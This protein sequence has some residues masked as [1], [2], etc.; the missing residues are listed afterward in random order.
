MGV[1]IGTLR[2]MNMRIENQVYCSKRRFTEAI[3]KPGLFEG[4]KDQLNLN[5]LNK[6]KVLCIIRS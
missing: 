6:K 4:K 2:Y 5:C 1:T 3:K